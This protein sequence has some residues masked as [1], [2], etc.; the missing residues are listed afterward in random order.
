MNDGTTRLGWCR[1]WIGLRLDQLVAL[2]QDALTSSPVSL[3]PSLT[4]SPACLV[5]ALA[6]SAA[7]S[8]WRRSLSVA[9]PTASLALPPSSSALLPT[10]SPIPMRPPD[11]ASAGCTRF[12]PRLCATSR[13]PTHPFGCVSSADVRHGRVQGG[14][15]GVRVHR[16]RHP[17]RTCTD[18]DPASG[19]GRVGDHR[20][21]C[22]RAE[23]RDRAPLVAGHLARGCG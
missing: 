20:Q 16:H 4:A 2:F 5:F 17:V 21:G 9:S 7:P 15:H 1:R 14:Q 10:L 11:F 12:P 22:C 18:R 19:D 23:R 13:V 3:T 8:A 6:W